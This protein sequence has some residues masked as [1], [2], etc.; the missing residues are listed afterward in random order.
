MSFITFFIKLFFKGVTDN[1]EKDV[2]LRII[3][4]FYLFI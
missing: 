1:I 2:D 4:A 3:D